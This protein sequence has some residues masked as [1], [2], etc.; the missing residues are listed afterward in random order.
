[1]HNLSQ[2]KERRTLNPEASHRARTSLSYKLVLIPFGV[3]QCDKNTPFCGQCIEA[4]LVCEGYGRHHSVWINSTYGGNRR[5]PSVVR[6]R[7]SDPSTITLN[8]SLMRVARENRYVG[9]YLSAFFPNGRLLLQEASY[10]S[11]A[12][13]IKYHDGICRSEKTLRFITLAHGLS[14]LATRDNDSQLKFKGVE[15]HRM[16]L[17]EMRKVVQD[18]QRATGDGLLAAVRLFRFYEVSFSSTCTF[19]CRHMIRMLNFQDFIWC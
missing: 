9:L 14:M 10:I 2:E 15:A 12:G 7:T 13:W 17:Q 11:T 16:A 8:D 1:M 4:G 18:R 5:T 3:E 6:T 19:C